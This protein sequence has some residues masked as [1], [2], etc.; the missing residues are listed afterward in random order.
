MAGRPHSNSV[1]PSLE[2]L[3]TKEEKAIDVAE[4]AF[5]DQFINEIISSTPELR[6]FHGHMDAR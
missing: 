5:T 6:E 4:K 2:V 3:E 1:P